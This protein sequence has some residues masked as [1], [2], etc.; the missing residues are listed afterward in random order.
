MSALDPL[1]GRVLSSGVELELSAGL[2]FTGGLAATSNPSTGLTD[3]TTAAPPLLNRGNSGAAISLSLSAELQR[4]TLTANATV[5]IT[6]GPAG[7]SWVEFA[8]DATGGRTLTLSGVTWAGAGAPTFVTTASHVSIV[9]FL[10]D[11]TTVYASLW[12]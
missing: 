6:P 8:Q 4:V 5:T 3:V 2:N 11:G 7:L 1:L 12:T 10:S 9:Q